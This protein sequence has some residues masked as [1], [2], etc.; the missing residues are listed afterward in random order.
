[1]PVS[2]VNEKNE[3]KEPEDMSSK[4]DPKPRKV[5]P[6]IPVEEDEEIDIDNDNPLS[7]IMGEPDLTEEG[8]DQEMVDTPATEEDQNPISDS[9]ERMLGVSD[10]Y[11]ELFSEHLWETTKHILMYSEEGRK[12]L[13][14]IRQSGFDAS[15]ISEEEQE[16]LSQIR[17]ALSQFPD[18][19]ELSVEVHVTPQ[20]VQF[21]FSLKRE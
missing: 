16:C 9:G 21:K 17:H 11:N 10:F 7:M 6:P 12:M 13:A 3:N 5:L 1:M 20:P 14:D 8:D 19:S 18:Q 2:I 4:P 15:S